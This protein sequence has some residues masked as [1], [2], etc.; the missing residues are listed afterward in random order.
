MSK[1]ERLLQN[2]K[3]IRVFFYPRMKIYI[4]EKDLYFFLE[5]VDKP[6]LS[7]EIYKLDRKK[8]YQ[9]HDFPVKLPKSN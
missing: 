8:A 9:K 7:K 5:F 1:F 6:K 2:M 4:K 3:I